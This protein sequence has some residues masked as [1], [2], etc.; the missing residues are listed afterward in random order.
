MT[1]E[2]AHRVK[3]TIAVLQSIVT[4]TMRP[5][6]EQAGVRDAIVERFAA[7]SRAHDLLLGKDFAAAELGELVRRALSVHPGIFDVNGQELE[8]SPQASLSFALV[9][10]E[11]ATNSAKYGSLRNPD[12]SVLISWTTTRRITDE[13]LFVFEWKEQG[14]PPTPKPTRTGFGTRLIKS[15]LS[16]WGTV[17]MDYEPNGFRLGFEGALRELTHAVVPDF[18]IREDALP[19]Q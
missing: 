6:P 17:T 18:E 15:T 8:L 11:L 16:G 4:H 9:L 3:N 1:R 19:A 10:H 5:F 2:L 12:G 14:G 7:L 13:D